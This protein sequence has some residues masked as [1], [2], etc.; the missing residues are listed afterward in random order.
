MTSTGNK[1]VDNRDLT[2]LRAAWTE[3]NKTA[4]TASRKGADQ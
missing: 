4:T 3:Y 2:A 1:L